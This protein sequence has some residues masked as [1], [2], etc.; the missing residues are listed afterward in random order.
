M[1]L[2]LG[3]LTISLQAEKYRLG[4]VAG[5]EKKEA[6][7]PSHDEEVS[8]AEPSPPQLEDV[9]ENFYTL[10]LRALKKSDL[11]EAEGY[12]DRVLTLNPNH[13][14]AREGINLIMKMYDEPRHP[15]N[16]ER[17][18]KTAQKEL[19]NQLKP[20]LERA[21]ELEDWSKVN[22]LSEKIL[23][24][25]PGDKDVKIIQLRARRKLFFLY[26]ERAKNYEKQGHLTHAI[27]AY[28]TAL[29]YRNDASL[30]ARI[31]EIRVKVMDKNKSAAEELY[32]EALAEAQKGEYTHATSLCK[33][34]LS[35]NPD[36][37]E[38]QKM[39]KRLNSMRVR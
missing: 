27:D 24:V 5:E 32:I 35:L 4:D 15:K 31:E 37:I 29:Q 16:S 14:G 17:R 39:L 12:F 22:A 7:N 28:Q 9:V 25:D 2:I 6:S 11:E 21:I 34:V 33:K 13:K 19:V 1:L 20:R 10:G 26:T 23:A 30:R 38:A 18:K 8:E 36:H 3:G